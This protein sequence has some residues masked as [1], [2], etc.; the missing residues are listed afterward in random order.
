M[1]ITTAPTISTATQPSQP[2][3]I[4]QPSPVLSSVLGIKPATSSAVPSSVQSVSTSLTSSLPPSSVSSSGQ[5]S[6]LSGFSLSMA[7]PLVSNSGS[8]LSNSAMSMG[9]PL[10]SS[11]NPSSSILSGSHLMSNP[12]VSQVFVILCDFGEKTMYLLTKWEGWMGNYLAQCHYRE[13]NI[14]LPSLT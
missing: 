13:S 7:A 6:D 10:V 14:F 2:N 4:P 5:T 9:D 8:I 12:G 3:S 1:S 11:S